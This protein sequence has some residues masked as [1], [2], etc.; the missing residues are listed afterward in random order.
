MIGVVGPDAEAERLASAIEGRDVRSGDAETVLAAGPDVVAAVGDAA[1]TAVA[2]AGVSVPVLPVET[3]AALEPVT[4]D[5]APAVL[6]RSVDEG[7][8]TTELPVVEATVGDEPAARGVFE[9]ML[10][11]SEPARIS[12]F[13]VEAPG[14][15]DR[16]RADGV[17][18]ATPAGSGGYA[19]AVGGPVL[20]PDVAGLV[21][22]PVAPFTTGPTVRVASAA[23]D[24]LVRVERDE[25]DVELLVD[26]DR[27]AGVPPGLPTT[28]RTVGHLRTVVDPDR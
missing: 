6:A 12:E 8:E 7:V 9:A 5:R 22:V 14:G 10:V 15:T 27:V 26:G 20:G 18:V 3:D 24:L 17:V 25:G 2:R 1:V 28:I 19:A 21:A 11:T 13:T 16:L 4:A 23:A